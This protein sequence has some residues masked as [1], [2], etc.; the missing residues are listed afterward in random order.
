[1]NVDEFFKA[2]FFSFEKHQS[3]T[4]TNQSINYQSKEKTKDQFHG[5]KS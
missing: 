2:I 4:L 3:T 5:K 1:M